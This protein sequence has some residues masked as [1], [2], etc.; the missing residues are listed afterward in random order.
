MKQEKVQSHLEMKD[1]LDHDR[2]LEVFENQDRDP[3][4]QLIQG[5]IQDLDLVPLKHQDQIRKVL[6]LEHL[7]KVPGHR[8]YLELQGQDQAL[9]N[10]QNQ[11]H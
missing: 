5:R 11:D 7:P 1:I 6:I 9:E 8:Q 3:D 2:D 4:H 10:S